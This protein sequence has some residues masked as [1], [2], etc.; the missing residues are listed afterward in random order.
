[1]AGRLAGGE[2]YAPA[3]DTFFLADHIR[4]EGGAAAL[5]IGSGSGYLTRLLRERFSLVV[6]TDINFDVLSNQTYRT[7]NLVCCHGASALAKKFDLIVCNPPYLATEGITD[8]ATD[9]GRGGLEAA[10]RIIDTVPGCLSPSGR[11]LVITSS[12]SDYGGLISHCGSLGMESGIIARKRLFFEELI[13]IRARLSSQ[14][15][16]CGI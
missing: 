10:R 4:N 8:I 9:G 7:P 5:D 6:G 2:E 11:F 16:S 3:E 13:L 15:P 12:L 14:Q 1:M